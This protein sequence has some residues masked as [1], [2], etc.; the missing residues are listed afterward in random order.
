MKG[1]VIC[2]IQEFLSIYIGD[3]FVSICIPHIHGSY[4]DGKL[5]AKGFH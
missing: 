4:N 2:E 1:V 5:F 3:G